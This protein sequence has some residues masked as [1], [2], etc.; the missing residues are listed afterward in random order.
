[1]ST[2]SYVMWTAVNCCQGRSNVKSTAP[3]TPAW[4][5]MRANKQRPRAMLTCLGTSTRPFSFCFSKKKRGKSPGSIA[6]CLL[7]KSLPDPKAAKYLSFCSVITAI[8]TGLMTLPAAAREPIWAAGATGL[9][10]VTAAWPPSC[11][12][13]PHGQPQSATSKGGAERLLTFQPLGGPSCTPEA[14]GAPECG[15]AD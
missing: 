15:E 1:M 14:K 4:S 11:S 5:S 7:P 2:P 3:P 8:V 6:A 10:R 13:P 9:A 12:P